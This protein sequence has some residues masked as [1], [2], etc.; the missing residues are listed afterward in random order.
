MAEWDRQ[1]LGELLSAY[2]DG[3]LGSEESQQVERLLQK[4]PEAQRLLEEL[5]RT[6]SA[7]SSLPRH[8]APDAIAEDVQLHIER[9]ALLDDTEQPQITAGARR[10]PALAFLAMAAALTLVVV[11][12][13]VMTV[14][15]RSL[16]DDVNGPLTLAPAE[17]PEVSLG[18][19][20][21]AKHGGRGV[22]GPDAAPVSS[23]DKILKV[24]TLQQKLEAGEGL[25]CAKK[26]RFANEPVQLQ[27]TLPDQ[28][29]HEE[30]AARLV[31][32]LKE[33]GV[34]D[35]A[36]ETEGVSDRDVIGSFVHIGDPVGN[37]FDSNQRQVLVRVTRE[38]LYGML[39]EVER[40]TGRSD[41]VRLESPLGSC[42]GN[43]RVRFLISGLERAPAIALAQ[44]Q[45]YFYDAAEEGDRE[46][47][48]M[49]SGSPR[50][51][52]PGAPEVLEGVLDALGYDGVV[53][54]AAGAG[55]DE[56]SSAKSDDRLAS[57][58]VGKKGEIDLL[59]EGDDQVAL[60]GVADQKR[61]RRE[62]KRPAARRAMKR[63][64]SSALDKRPSIVERARKKLEDADRNRPAET[65]EPAA[66][67]A[68]A[69]VHG[70]TTP[71]VDVVLT[72]APPH[73]ATY[74]TLVLRID[75]GQPKRSEAAVHAKKSPPPKEV[76]GKSVE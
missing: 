5:R 30:L 38:D 65:E 62:G 49:A 60:Q 59:A 35:L 8:P 32:Y 67:L 23:A 26:H 18:E 70:P 43:S 39:G 27:V 41:N 47:V 76:P 7:V 25:A 15:K 29:R 64:R 3:E 45:A 56:A 21:K 11:G 2:V 40:V 12:W 51:P 61:S 53:T 16:F 13:Q 46:L 48:G 17:S 57:A 73:S 42:E 19:E 24:A 74:V 58:H 68:E 20:E 6:V 54:E 34:P 55:K 10:G 66:A 33:R 44:P 52:S 37:S 14:E 71:P 22:K 31:A 72:F 9:S 28:S 50:E 63:T 4:D 1:Q 75:I 36:D 69:P